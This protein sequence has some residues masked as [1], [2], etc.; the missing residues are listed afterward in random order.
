M[1]LRALRQSNQGIIKLLEIGIKHEGTLPMKIPW[2]NIPP[3]AI[4]FMAYMIAHEA[5]HRGQ[6][7]LATR[8]LGCR[9]PSHITNGIWQWKKWHAT[10]FNSG[11][12]SPKNRK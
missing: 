1:L 3:D 4:H 12:L 11:P 9:L 7:I 5:H 6:I 8:A 2:A 10:V